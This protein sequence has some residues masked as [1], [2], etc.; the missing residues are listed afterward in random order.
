MNSFRKLAIAC[1]SATFALVAIGGLVRAT[2][3]GLGCG[4]DWPHCNGRLAPAL[5]TRAEIIE[6]SHRAAAGVVVIL[7][8]LL[9][10]TAFRR[11][12]DSTRLL[13]TSV[14]ALGLVLSQ[15][16]IGALVVKLDLK[17]ESVVLHLGTAM[18]L[19]AVLVYLVAATSPRAEPGAGDRSL[20]RQAWG[21]ALSV[22][23]LLLVGSYVTG[24]GAGLV[25]P[26]WPLMNGTPLPD[27]G[28]EDAAVHF[29]HRALAAV[30]GGIVLLTGLRLIRRGGATAR[31]GRAAIALY[32][33]EV[34]IGAANVWTDLNAAFVTAHLA[35][36]ALIWG[37]LTGAAVL[38]HPGLERAREGLAPAG[39]AAL[40][41]SR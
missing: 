16:L 12:R 35:L 30:V 9:A 8:A 7:I 5:E 28:T 17:A 34:L 18:S 25:F 19:V 6:F 31:L 2:K 13:W 20:S 38:L 11:H 10:V 37:S 14:G 32:A 21:A 1:L 4:D 24:K 39:R 22:F 29:V 26:D 27:L 3:S 23:L 15:A 36:A 40:E 33:L 41:G